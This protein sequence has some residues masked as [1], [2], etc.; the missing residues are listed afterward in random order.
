MNK[1]KTLIEWYFKQRDNDRKLTT[2]L[3]TYLC[4]DSYAMVSWWPLR[5]AVYE[6]LS[7]EL[8]DY[9]YDTFE[10]FYDNWYD[11]IADTQELVELWYYEPFGSFWEEWATS[12]RVH[13]EIDPKQAKSYKELKTFEQVFSYYYPWISDE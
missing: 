9:W 8:W 1:Y 7:K 3:E 11:W 12:Y 10:Q 13:K 5:D 4:T 6:Y 2:A